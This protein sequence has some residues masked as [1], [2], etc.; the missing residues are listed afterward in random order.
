MNAKQDKELTDIMHGITEHS[1]QLMQNFFEKKPMFRST[2]VRKMWQIGED[3]QKFW[4]KAMQDPLLIPKMQLGYWRDF[5]QLVDTTSSR[6]LGNSHG[7]KDSKGHEHIEDRR[8]NSDEWQNHPLFSFISQHY[9]MFANRVLET[10]NSVKGVDENVQK[11]VDFYTQQTLD[12]ISP[13]NFILT[14]PDVLKATIDSKGENLLKGLKNMLADLERADSTFHIKM[15]DLDAF[16]IGKN[17]ATTK[18]KVVYENELMQLIQYKPTTKQV[19]H[20]PLLMI[21][22]WINKYYILDLS[23]NNSLVKWA[24]SQGI[25]VFMISW[26]NP[27][28]KLGK[29]DFSDYML[30]GPISALDAIEKHLGIK[31]VNALGFC[32]GGTLLATT[33]AYMTSHNDKR[34]KSGT[35][36]ATLI[37]FSDPGD[38]SIF[39]DEKQ[40]NNLEKEM[41][42]EGY[43]DGGKMAQTFNLLRANDLIWSY[44]IKNY[45]K[46]QEPFPFDILFWNSDATNMPA[47]MHSTYLRSM[48]LNNRLIQ[49]N[50]MVLKGTPIDISKVTT[51]VYFI[52]TKRDH[53]AP[54]Q[55]TFNG[56]KAHSGDKTFVLGKSGHIAGIINPPNKEKYGYYTH[57]SA[58]DNADHW[59]EGATYH[60]Y[61]WWPHWMDWLKKHSGELIEARQPDKGNLKPIES[62]P[63]RYVKVNLRQ[64]RKAKTN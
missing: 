61:S 32:I 31:E 2:D 59:L 6:W 37:D 50:E 24:V 26:V 11:K 33:L 63:G 3:Y 21:P 30:Q 17:V 13:S 48:Y 20:V 4:T 19:H 15:T 62:A 35:Y 39:I 57:D 47:K 40:I 60:E 23:E 22:P 56:F 12:A 53:I 16:K 5:F 49:P 54:W 1:Q 36:L 14:N 52:S 9:L 18:G 25:T 28:K 8:F 45:L 27:N 51:P 29:K 43:L 64:K 58:V 7:Q 46:G 34:I 10:I 41:A 42:R 55:T 44:Y 38:M